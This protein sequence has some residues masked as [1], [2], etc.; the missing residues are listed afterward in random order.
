MAAA[1]DGFEVRGF[2]RIKSGLRAEDLMG[3]Y[4]WF[5]TLDVDCGC[6]WNPAALAG[7]ARAGA[8]RDFAA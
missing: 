7:A 8:V 2:G 1:Y 5:A 4:T 6:I 3:K